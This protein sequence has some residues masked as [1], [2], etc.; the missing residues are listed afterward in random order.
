MAKIYTKTG[1][2][3]TTSLVGG[4]RIKKYDIVLDAYGTI[5]ELNSHIGLVIAAND[6]ASAT[7]DF[8]NSPEISQL[9][10]YSHSILTEIQTCLFVIGGMLATPVEHWDEYWSKDCNLNQIT[11]SLEKEID[12]LQEEVGPFKGFVLPQGSEVIARLHLC[13]TVCRRA[14]RIVSKI[15][16]TNEAYQTIAIYLNRLSDFFYILALYQHK[17]TEK[18]IVYWNSGRR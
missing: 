10:A 9:I 2:K 12:Q 13:R 3:G 5:D 17:I 18:E 8:N 6:Y 4:K 15:A 7:N 1:D 14:E 16:D 11:E